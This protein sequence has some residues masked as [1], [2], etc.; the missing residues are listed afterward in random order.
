VR[1]PFAG[2]S[3]GRGRPRLR[4]VPTCTSAL[5]WRSVSNSD[6]LSYLR[7]GESAAKAALGALADPEPQTFG[8]PHGARE[9]PAKEDALRMGATYLGARSVTGG[10]VSPWQ[11]RKQKASCGVARTDVPSWL[12]RLGL[13]SLT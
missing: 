10:G 9:I 11:A 8:T 7:G 12:E 4:H 2:R 6:T 5:E 3:R 1:I 13:D